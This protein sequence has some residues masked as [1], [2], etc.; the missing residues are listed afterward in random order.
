MRLSAGED[1]TRDWLEDLKANEARTYEKNTPIVEAVAAG[2]IALGLVNHYY[3]ALVKEEQP[4]AA[5]ANH[6]LP[7]DDPVRSSAS[8]VRACSTAPTTRRGRGLRLVPARGRAAAFYAEEAEE[9]EY[10]LVDGHRA[11]RASRHSTTLGGPDV[12]LTSFGTELEAT[13]EL[14]RETGWPRERRAGEPTP[15]PPTPAP[16]RRSPRRRSSRSCCCRSPT[17]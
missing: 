12:D 13:V 16:A 10:P 6:F 15:V 5:V 7:G 4:D 9:T 17:C 14:L 8:Q 2:E 3:L 1:R 11:R